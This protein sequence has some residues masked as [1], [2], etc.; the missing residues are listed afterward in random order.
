MVLQLQ[1][2]RDFMLNFVLFQLVLLILLTCNLTYTYYQQ[3]QCLARCM[4]RMW[5]W[6]CLVCRIFLLC[7]YRTHLAHFYA[8]HKIYVYYATNLTYSMLICPTKTALVI[9]VLRF[10]PRLY[11]QH[12]KGFEYDE[13]DEEEDDEDDDYEDIVDDEHRNGDENRKYANAVPE[14]TAIP[15]TEIPDKTTVTQRH[16]YEM[17]HINDSTN[18][19]TALIKDE[20]KYGAIDIE[21]NTTTTVAQLLQQNQKRQMERMQRLEQ[22]VLQPPPT[23]DVP[24]FLSWLANL[25]PGGN[26]RRQPP[27]PYQELSRDR[28]VMKMMKKKKSMKKMKSSPSFCT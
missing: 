20:T 8:A 7:E 6:R 26:K 18:D 11:L 16:N 4:C 28:E 1:Q 17:H 24:P 27:N 12:D 23:E 22:S 2:G 9:L 19:T 3:F 21:Q 25:L 15:T 14:E 5:C 13:D 10:G